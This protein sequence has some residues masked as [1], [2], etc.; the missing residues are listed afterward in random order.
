[1]NGMA[2]S[3]DL[4]GDQLSPSSTINLISREVAGKVTQITS[5]D[6]VKSGAGIYERDADTQNSRSLSVF[7]IH[8]AS[9]SVESRQT[10][11]APPFSQATRLNLRE[12][13][14]WGV[15]ASCPVIMSTAGV[16]QITLKR[17]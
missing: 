2:G 17:P 15:L 6:E 13:P 5:K 1:M 3:A 10:M 4:I 11:G 8:C 14:W 16:R 12:S 7:F 9:S